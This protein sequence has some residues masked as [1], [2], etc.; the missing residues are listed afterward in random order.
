M[1]VKPNTC[2]GYVRKELWDKVL[3]WLTD[4]EVKDKDRL[5]VIEYIGGKGYVVRGE[6]ADTKIVPL[7]ELE[8]GTIEI[9]P[10]EEVEVEDEVD[11]EP[12]V[13]EEGDWEEQ[14]TDDWEAHADE[15]G[16]D[17]DADLDILSQEVVGEPEE[18]EEPEP[19]VEPEPEVEP[20]VDTSAKIERLKKRT[21]KLARQVKK[22]AKKMQKPKRV[23]KDDMEVLGTDDRGYE[24]VEEQTFGEWKK[25]RVRDGKKLVVCFNYEDWE[26][27]DWE[28]IVDGINPEELEQ[29]E[30]GLAGQSAA[31][32]DWWWTDE[33]KVV[34]KV[35]KIMEAIKD[36]KALPWSIAR[37]VLGVMGIQVV[38]EI[39]EHF[40]EL[41]PYANINRLVTLKNLMHYLRVDQAE[42]YESI[43]KE[44]RAATWKE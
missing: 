37:D 31:G 8:D 29:Q 19:V 20:E 4:P 16:W 44:I 22:V 12:E 5:E 9:P 11:P 40:E 43:Y 15:D 23:R 2:K 30:M 10:T 14:L 34:A 35:E 1:P 6:G 39:V 36:G 17:L 25:Y 7:T 28:E 24:I 18:P 33:D 3:A 21:K 32:K 26:W 42:R 38:R 27:A 41:Y 13:E